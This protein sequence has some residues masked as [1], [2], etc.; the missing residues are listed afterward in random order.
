MDVTCPDPL[1]VGQVRNSTPSAKIDLFN[2]IF[3]SS[4]LATSS[5]ES[6][7]LIRMSEP[8]LLVFWL[9]E[10]PPKILSKGLHQKISPNCEKISS[11]LI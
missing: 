8:P 5:S 11:I 3:Y 4:P 10:R 6:F 1:H 9:P 7:N 2:L